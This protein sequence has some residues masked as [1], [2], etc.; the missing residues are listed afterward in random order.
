MILVHDHPFGVSRWHEERLKRD[1]LPHEQG[2]V[3]RVRVRFGQWLGGREVE[4][5]AFVDT[6]AD[7]TVVSWRWAAQLVDDRDQPA[8]PVDENMN[9]CEDVCVLVGG[10]ALAVPRGPQGPYMASQTDTEA[11][12]EQ[13]E[14]MPGYEDI[15]LGRDFLSEHKL[16]LVVDADEHCFSLLLPDGASSIGARALVRDTLR[17]CAGGEP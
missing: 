5:D 15:L 12:S 17:S 3:V 8:I 13:L 1:P 2:L 16:L 11:E 7:T 4:A 10:R 14:E 6:G 9:I